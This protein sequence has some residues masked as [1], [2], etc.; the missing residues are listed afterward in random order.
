MEANG[1][2]NAANYAREMWANGLNGEWE[3]AAQAAK[4][5]N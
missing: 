4:L 3:K 2:K 1:H 5:K